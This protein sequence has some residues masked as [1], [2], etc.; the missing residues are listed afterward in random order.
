MDFFI[1]GS[2]A[3]TA[4]MGS[5][6]RPIVTSRHGL[7]R[8][9]RRIDTACGTGQGFRGKGLDLLDGSEVKSAAI[10]S[11]VDRPKVEPQHGN[12]GT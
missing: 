11:G 12:L 9:A 4:Q 5:A 7:H 1:V 2:M 6:H 8:T 10:I 3:R